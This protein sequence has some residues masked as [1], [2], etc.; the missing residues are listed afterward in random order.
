MSTKA[1]AGWNS[2]GNSQ[3]RR[4]VKG[5]P[6]LVALCAQR[7][8]EHLGAIDAVVDHENPPRGAAS[9]AAGGDADSRWR[10]FASAT[11]ARGNRTTNSLPA[12]GRRCGRRRCRGVAPPGCARSSVRG[13]GLPETD[14]W[15]DAPER[16]DRTRGQ[17]ARCDSDACVTHANHDLVVLLG[18]S[19]RDAPPGGVYFAALVSRLENTWLRRMASPMTT[20]REG[21]PRQGHASAGRAAASRSRWPSPRLP[22]SP[23]VLP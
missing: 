16:T 3:C 19:D 11:C 2:A 4:P 14:R 6:S 17:N 12:S 10:A 23:R 7:R 8:C 18:R 15:P 5:N 22:Q 21:R 9:T 13:P 1:M 20:D